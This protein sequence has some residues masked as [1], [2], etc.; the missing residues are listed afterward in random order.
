MATS[1]LLRWP[2]PSQRNSEPPPFC[3]TWT[4]FLTNVH[5]IS[6]T[7]LSTTMIS[8][9]QRFSL[10]QLT[11]PHNLKGPFAP[12]TLADP[13]ILSYSRAPKRA[14]PHG[15][16]T[17]PD[18]GEA[19]EVWEHEAPEGPNSTPPEELLDNTLRDCISPNR[20]PAE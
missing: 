8:L 7:F 6:A 17:P 20:T 16:T 19:S 15:F 4:R 2:F 13:T 12:H 3:S 5:P 9:G 18:S 14:P 1:R 10:L 11:R